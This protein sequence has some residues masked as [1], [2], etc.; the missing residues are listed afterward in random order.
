MRNALAPLLFDDEQLADDKN[1]RD[2]VAP[3]EPSFEAK[4]KKSNRKTADGLPIHSFKSLLDE[5]GMYMRNYCSIK[6]L[7]TESKLTVNQYTELSPV[8]KRSFE[9]LNL[10]VQ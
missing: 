7:N 2:P 9:L 10:C 8:Q 6:E 3:A 1:T 4:L 5:L